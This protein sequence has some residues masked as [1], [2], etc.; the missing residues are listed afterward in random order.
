MKINLQFEN[1]LAYIKIKSFY[2]KYN[3]IIKGVTL[4][5]LLIIVSGIPHAINMF[6][7]PYYENDEGTYMS[8]AWSLLKFGRLAPYTYWYDHSPLGWFLIA[9]WVKLTG[10]FFTFGMSVNSG[11]VLMLVIHIISSIFL[12]FIAKKLTHSKFP[13]IVAVLIFSLSPLAIYFQRRVLLDNMMVFWFLASWAILMKDS[14]KVKDAIFAGLL[15]GIAVLTKENAIFLLPGFVYLLHVRF[16]PTV[17]RIAIVEFLFVSLSLI[18]LYFLYAYLKKELFAVGF[19]GNNSP[20]VSLLE[21]LKMQASRGNKLPIWDRGSDFRINLDYWLLKDKLLIMSGT[22]AT[23]LVLFYSF[24]NKFLKIPLIFSLFFA[25]FLLRGSLVINFYIVP[26]IPLFALNVSLL[27]FMF[28]KFLSRH[29]KFIYFPLAI[30][31]SIFIIYPLSKSDTNHWKNNETG[32]QIA[33]YKWI[34]ENVDS[35]SKIVIDC[36][37]YVDFHEPHSPGGKVFENADWFWKYW[38]DPEIQ[39]KFGNDWRNVDYLLVT[40][41]MVNQIGFGVEN[42][43][44]LRLV[45]D[46]S[47]KRALFGPMSNTF[48]D[49]K[50]Y[51]STNGDWAGVFQLRPKEELA[52][53]TSWEF[54]KKSFIKPD[55]QVIDPS[56]E[57]TTSEGQSYALLRAVWM[58]DR[59]SFDTSWNWTKNH[60]QVRGDSLFSWIYAKDKNSEFKVLDKNSASDADE[61]TALALIF[62]YKRWSE[63]RYL[64]DSIKILEDIWNKEVVNINNRYYLGFS[65]DPKRND[66]VIV[67]PSYL[68]PASYKIFAAVDSTHPW[69]KLSSDSYYLLNKIGENNSTYLPPN[70][71]YISKDN[72]IML[73]KEWFGDKSDIY[74]YDAFR[75]LFRVTLDAKWFKTPE[76]NQYLQ[77]ISPFLTER[78]NSQKRFAAEYSVN[79]KTEAN[80]SSISTETGPL[81]VMYVNNIKFAD[82]LYQELIEKKYNKVEGYWG[83]K[84]NYYDQ[85]WAWFITALYSGGLPNLWTSP[86]NIAIE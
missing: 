55:G 51:K 72:N 68:S 76:S 73:A 26:M 20:H 82:E 81:A 66:G 57:K 37:P 47:K 27:G 4:T 71:L 11:R 32:P 22:I 12:F 34:T 8:Q 9:L 3:S 54:Y 7:F 36:Y 24:F 29:I 65:A 75:T 15:F 56:G 74:G 62:A 77:N 83:E 67:N 38:Y 39:D 21:T 40:H 10:G 80:F 52:L 28:V 23:L 19:L 31:F 43:D 41:E 53:S 2:D 42:K 6:N 70:F 14:I 17:R 78:W 44:T 5:I 61:D 59:D 18:S 85:N 64:F 16:T 33:A 49:F 50:N 30:T 79:G 84:S 86:K 48:I 63:P 58:N 13:G 46:N 1:R 35:N 60:L 69:L 45:Y 25:A